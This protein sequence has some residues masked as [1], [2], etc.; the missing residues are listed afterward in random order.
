MATVEIERILGSDDYVKVVVAITLS[1]KVGRTA[2][3][4]QPSVDFDG[5]DDTAIMQK[6]DDDAMAK[7]VAARDNTSPPVVVPAGERFA[8]LIGRKRPIPR[9]VIGNNPGSSSRTESR[10][11]GAVKS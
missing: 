3:T 2:L 11:A 1:G 7:A 6:I 10:P 4:Y 8:A 9:E 5:L